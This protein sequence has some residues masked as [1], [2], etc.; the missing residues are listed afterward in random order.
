M[1]QASS[2]LLVEDD[3]ALA[4]AIADYLRR[5]GYSVN[6][7]DDGNVAVRAIIAEQPD[8]VILDVMLPGKDGLA[9][10]REVRSR[11]QGYIIMF[12]AREDEVDQIVGLE[13]GADDYLMKPV[14]PR[15]LL[16]KV[17]AFLRR[18]ETAPARQG[19]EEVLDF[20]DLSIDLSQR[21]VSLCGEE[22]RLTSAEFDLLVIL[23]RQA[24]S[25]LS[26]AEIMQQLSG[27]RYDGLDRTID[28]KVSLLRRKLG[29][30]SGVPSR[31]KTVRSKG[32]VFVP[33]GW[34]R[35]R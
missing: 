3:K 1:T 5:E 33:G 26:R 22:I 6:V 25:V 4:D 7:V 20:D 12:T 28:N 17:K 30:D 31:I 10:C 13:L 29:D 34:N 21:T 14:K 19:Q 11:F 9:V 27:G 15:L 8:L 16:A 2:I 23:A 18:A 24:G 35:S 32:Y